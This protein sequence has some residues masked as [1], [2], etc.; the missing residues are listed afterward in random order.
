MG[1]LYLKSIALFIVSISNLMLANA[2]KSNKFSVYDPVPGLD[3]SP[4]YSVK[5]KQKGSEHWTETFMLFTECTEAKHCTWGSGIV[6]HLANWSNSYLN[7]EMKDGNSI[8]LEITM[9]FG[10]ETI[11]KAVVHPYTAS[12]ECVVENGKAYVTISHT[13]LFTVDINGQMDDQDT[14]KLPKTRGGGTNII[15]R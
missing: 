14:G 9:L 10:N 7:I 1:I 3:P 13:G 8:E 12:D 15:F 11:S 2:S 6:K 5:I 4:Y